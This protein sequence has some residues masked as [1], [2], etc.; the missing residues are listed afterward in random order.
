MLRAYD[1]ASAAIPGMVVAELPGRNSVENL[2]QCHLLGL[3]ASAIAVHT[4]VSLK[5]TSTKCWKISGWN[6]IKSLKRS[7]CW[8]GSCMDAENA[9]AARRNG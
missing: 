4:D 5:W 1:D 7:S 3:P 8:N 6:A 9:G 2:Q